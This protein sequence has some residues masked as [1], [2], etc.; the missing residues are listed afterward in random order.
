MGTGDAANQILVGVD[1]SADGLRAVL[2]AMREALASDASLWL[3]HV[4]DVRL[5]SA[6]LWELVADPAELQRSGEAHLREA[7]ALLE[8]EGFPGSRVRSDVVLG[9]PGRELPRLS[10][11]ARLV[12]LGR[13]STSGLERMFVGSTSVAVASRAE[14]PAIVISA[15]STPH[16]TGRLHV[17]AVALTSWPAQGSIL[18]WGLREAEVRQARLRVV[19]VLPE[20]LGS[21]EGVVA[22]ASADLE[23]RLHSLRDAHPGTAI[24]AEVILGNPVDELVAISRM[25]DLLILDAGPHPAPLTG[26]TRGVMAH[27]SCPVGIWR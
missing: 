19:F 3:V 16:R 6:G 4:V 21:H 25:V 12:V 11:D 23:T 14:C 18:E 26:P 5:M 24:D 2:Y 20:P 27:A 13:R 22:A 10:A 17:V 7:E 15:A 1:G 8:T 9:D